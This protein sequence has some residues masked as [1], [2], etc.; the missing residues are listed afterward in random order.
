LLFGH[1]ARRL[2]GKARAG[3][4]SDL[5]KHRFS[6]RGENPS[7]QIFRVEKKT[8]QKLPGDGKFCRVTG[9]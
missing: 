7:C 2:I 8:G 4:D 5:L 6:A 3:T 1:F 9:K